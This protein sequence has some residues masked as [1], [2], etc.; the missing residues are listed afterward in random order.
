LSRAAGTDLSTYSASGADFD[1]A[2]FHGALAAWCE[3]YRFECSKPFLVKWYNDKRSDIAGG[4]QR[5]EAPDTAV[6]FALYSI[7][8]Y[9]DVIVDHFRRV[10]P[11]DGF[12]DS[13]TNEILGNLRSSLA[14]EL[15]AR[16]INTDMGPPYFHVQTVGCVAA[17]DQH[18]E[19]EEFKGDDAAHWREE[20]SDALEETRDTKMWGTEPAQL[21]KIFA[22]NVHPKWGGW[23]AYR[24]LLILRG[25]SAEHLQPPQPLQFLPPTEAKR[26]ISEYNRRHQECLWRDLTADGHPPDCRYNTDEYFF[27]TETS[28]AKR[29]RWLELKADQLEKEGAEGGR[30]GPCCGKR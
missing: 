8:G 18:V 17:I 23:Y 7:P 29:K 12:V 20:L 24:G 3:P 28:P 9:L 15:D 22:V 16:V 5:I 26:I 25:T 1:V 4:T 6:C 11:K 10:R 14:P 30:W 21:R 2:G 27:F 19:A 13:A